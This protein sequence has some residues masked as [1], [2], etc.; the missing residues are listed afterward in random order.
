MKLKF[1]YS[2]IFILLLSLNVVVKAQQEHTTPATIVDEDL[3]KKTFFTGGN[4]GLQFGTVTM[5]DVSPQFGYYVLENISVGVGFTYQFISDR[6][7]SPPA[8]MHVL[9]GRVFTR[10]HFPFYNSIF[11]YGEYEYLAY[12]T[13]VFS[14]NLMPEWISL[15]NVL[16]GIGY[17]Q[18]ITG[19]SAITL[20]ILWNFNESE[21][22][23]YQNPVIRA[24]FDIGI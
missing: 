5:V 20:M 24:G 22:N 2:L 3:F 4:L 10:L 6:R 12:K 19:R 15:S 18:R 14:S 17:R 9:G 13:N 16:A 23:L 21:Y 1:H 7:Y 8:T 11:G